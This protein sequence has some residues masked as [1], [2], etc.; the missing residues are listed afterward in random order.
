MREVLA[1]D[2]VAVAVETVGIAGFEVFLGFL[3]GREIGAVVIGGDGRGR[4]EEEEGC[5]EGDGER[6]ER[7]ETDD[8]ASLV[9]H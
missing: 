6:E 7:A 5:P 2:P 4:G 8:C 1:R 9:E 3:L